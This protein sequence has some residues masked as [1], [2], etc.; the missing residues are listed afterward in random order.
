LG[1][2]AVARSGR[3]T[4]FFVGYMARHGQDAHWETPMNGELTAALDYLEKERGIDREL[5][6]Q[7]MEAAIVAAAKKG[8]MAGR[9]LRVQI[10]R[11]TGDIKAWS[12]QLV[13][14]VVRDRYTEITQSRARLYKADAQLGEEIEVEIDPKYLGR[15]AA[16]TVKQLMMQRIRQ[17]ERDNLFM[18]YKDRVNDIVSGTVRRF[19]RGDVV[20]DLGKCEAVMPNKERVPTEEYNVGDRVRALLLN[21]EN[22]QGGLS[23]ILSR[24]HPDFVKRLFALEVSEIG[25]NTVEIKA[26]AREAGFRTKIAVHSSDEK[27]DPVGA[28]VGMRGSRVKNIVRELNGEKVDIIRWSPDIRTF[29]ANALQPAKLKN[30]E[31]DE[32]AR[33]IKIIVDPD[34]LSLAI[35]KRGQNARLT[36]KLTGWKVDIEA[37]ATATMGFEDQ[38]AHAIEAIAAV[39]GL[40]KATAEVL[41]KHGFATLEVILEASAEDIGEIPEIGAEKAKAIIAAVQSHVLKAG[42]ASAPLAAAV[43]PATIHDQPAQTVS[44]KEPQ[45]QEQPR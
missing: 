2:E 36:S 31:I 39:E 33:R 9:D 27:V 1:E 6:V 13:V 12:K 43:A 23:M 44:P 42:G 25:D 15:I 18:E 24:A 14:E 30:L 40:D 8:G 4:H 32:A 29:V 21:V 3:Q 5:I 38:M 19:E 7:S 17:C 35:G 41:V 37:D 34:Q 11:T 20:V 28:C 26:I 10:D 45:V 16:Q 22:E